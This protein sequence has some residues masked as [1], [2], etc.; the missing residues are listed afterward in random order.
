M[1]AKNISYWKIFTLLISIVLISV[2]AIFGVACQKA[3]A[4]DI[5][6]A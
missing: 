6:I 4:N 3:N 5:G 1:K 2:C